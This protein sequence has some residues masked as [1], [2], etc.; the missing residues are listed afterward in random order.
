M[1]KLKFSRLRQTKV[2]VDIH[3]AIV[4]KRAAKNFRT[5]YISLHEDL[6]N[7]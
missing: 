5:S 3:V 6:D 7:I 2:L 4:L 1:Y